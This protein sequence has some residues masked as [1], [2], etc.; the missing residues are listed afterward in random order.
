MVANFCGTTPTRIRSSP[1]RVI[2]PPPIPSSGTTPETVA[3]QLA[4]KSNGGAISSYSFSGQG[5]PALT[6]FTFNSC[7]F[8]SCHFDGT[9]FIQCRFINCL[10]INCTFA[11]TVLTGSIIKIC[12]FTSCTM[13]GTT[14]TQ[15]IISE[16][17]FAVCKMTGAMFLKAQLTECY[18]R[19]VIMDATMWQAAVLT[20]NT[21]MLCKMENMLL[22]GA[23]LT[24]GFYRM[25]NCNGW[26]V[27]NTPGLTGETFDFCQLQA[28]VFQ[29]VPLT[30]VVMHN[31]VL[32]GSRFSIGNWNICGFFACTFANAQFERLNIADTSF[33][34]STTIGVW[35][36]VTFTRVRCRNIVASKA[37][38]S[39]NAWQNVDFTQA[40]FQFVAFSNSKWIDVGFVRGKISF[41]T[42][43]NIDVQNVIYEQMIPTGP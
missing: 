26:R 2:P 31:C 34:R 3:D 25:C 35:N 18:F 1:I 36:Y 8:T 37:E 15:T 7:T 19:L 17:L 23:T 9:P 6:N 29:N 27:T 10:F 21:F 40:I 16:T 12:S 39:M 22:P 41:P 30:D 11:A 38:F 24:G 4:N 28:V 42:Y 43:L 13:V 32:G 14:F 5:F 33:E 20:T